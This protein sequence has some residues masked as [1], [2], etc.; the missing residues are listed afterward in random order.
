M[1]NANGIYL[2]RPDWYRSFNSAM[3]W[4]SAKLPIYWARIPAGYRGANRYWR[5]Y[6]T[7]WPS[8]C[9]AAI[10]Q[11]GQP[12]GYRTRYFT[13]SGIIGSK[14]F[15]AKN[16]QRFKHLFHSKHEKKPKQIKGLDGM[17]SL[18]RLSEIVWKKL[19]WNGFRLLSMIIGCASNGFRR[20]DFS[21]LRIQIF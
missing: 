8:R 6:P 16:Y 14:E 7:K 5:H 21:L 10:Y 17:Y 19:P 15:V 12:H 13:D 20:N 1:I 11:A 2:N 3:G 9:S 18:K 4:P